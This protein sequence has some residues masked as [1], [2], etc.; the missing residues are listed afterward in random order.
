MVS[1]RSCHRTLI[2]V[3]GFIM[4]EIGLTTKLFNVTL[5]N[6]SN[7]RTGWGGRKVSSPLLSEVYAAADRI[8]DVVVSTPVVSFIGAGGSEGIYL[9]P[10]ILQAT[11]SFKI[12]GV[13]NWALSISDSVIE[14]G[15][16]TASAGNTA[17]AL[18]YVARL[19][20]IRA[21][22]VLPDS[23]PEAK[24]ESLLKYK[25]E[26]QPM[27]LDEVLS[28]MLE[29]KWREVDYNY[30]NPWG[31]PMMIAGHGTIGLEVMEQVHDVETIYIPVGGG[32]LIAGVGSTI[33]MLN[34]AVRIVGVQS[35][36]CPTLHSSFREGRSVWVNV[37]P[38]ICDGTTSPLIVDEMFPLLKDVIDDVHLVSEKAVLGSM[39]MLT[40]YNGFIV[41]G[42]GA[43]SLAAALEIPYASRG[44]S[45]CLLTGKNTR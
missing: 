13:Y 22:S 26:P 40:R 20:G 24:L 28:Y 39:E 36:S 8:G 3:S 18:G 43:L 5:M 10:E 1:R 25:V 45:V 12:R 34:P 21:H 33:K 41:E 44:K 35:E 9:K 15:L 11:G 7:R 32:G 30:L 31:E 23:V 29:E 27:P 2:T 14:K 37:Q 6:F 19:R 38:T 4:T 42:S 17:I 16:S